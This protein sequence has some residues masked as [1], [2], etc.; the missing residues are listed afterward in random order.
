MEYCSTKLQ[1]LELRSNC[2]KVMMCAVVLYSDSGVVKSFGYGVEA[3]KAGGGYVCCGWE[4][5][6]LV[7]SVPAS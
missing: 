1:Y 2:E 5:D 4:R 7:N 3:L 6:V